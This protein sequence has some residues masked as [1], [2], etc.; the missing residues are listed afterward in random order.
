VSFVPPQGFRHAATLLL[1]NRA[2]AIAAQPSADAVQAAVERLA[3]ELVALAADMRVPAEASHWL[4]GELDAMLN[5][6]PHAFD[7]EGARSAAAAIL[8]HTA[9]GQRPVEMCDL[10]LVYVPEDRLPVAAPLAIELSKRRVSVAFAPYEV[11]GPQQTTAALA[12]GLAHHRGGIVLATPAFRRSHGDYS[13]PA[14]PRI[15]IVTDPR[16]PATVR[17]LLDYAESL[18]TVS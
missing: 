8:A 5:R 18:R 4:A 6:L 16:A 11:T 17:E 13:L 1:T 14:V 7:R 15:R 12:D 9:A 10:F 2:R 3:H